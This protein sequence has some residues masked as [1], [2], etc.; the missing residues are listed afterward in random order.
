M[1]GF[2]FFLFLFDFFR[3]LHIT[4]SYSAY[5][6]SPTF[7]FIFPQKFYLTF[8]FRL[9]YLSFSLL[10]FPTFFFYR[11]H[12]DS[13][14]R[15]THGWTLY[16]SHIAFVSS[17]AFHNS[18]YHISHLI[19][20]QHVIHTAYFD[21]NNQSECLLYFYRPFLVEPWKLILEQSGTSLPHT[22]RVISFRIF[23][24][25]SICMFVIFLWSCNE[26]FQLIPSFPTQVTVR[27]LPFSGYCLLFFCFD[28]SMITS[29][30]STR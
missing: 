22:H 2:S 18:P 19:P 6:T 27:H 30:P 24:H 10:C 4:T 12:P 1:S 3:I 9:S 15:Q 13:D 20:P 29:Q 5:L 16:I 11:F 23:C 21:F 7:H 26:H 17:A 8:R 25:N 28:S 14:S